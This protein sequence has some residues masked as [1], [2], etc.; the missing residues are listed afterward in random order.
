MP[1]RLDRQRDRVGDVGHEVGVRRGAEG[2]AHAG[3]QVEVLDRRRYAVQRPGVRL[4]PAA[5]D[6]AR[7]RASSGVRGD[8]RA[9]LVGRARGSASASSRGDTSP[10]R[11]AA[12]CSSAVRS[13]SSLTRPTL[14]ASLQPTRGCR[15]SPK[16]MP[17]EQGLPR[18]LD[19]VVPDADG[20]PRRLAV[21]GLDQDPGDRVGAVT[22]VEDPHLVVDQLE[23]RDLRERLHQRLPQR[24]VEGVDRAVALAGLD[25]PHALGDAASRSPRRRPPPPARRGSASR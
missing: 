2:R 14:A 19:H 6:S 4:A 16:V 25:V 20:H 18:R 8:E 10:R 5:S 21:G 12:P 11:T 13:C 22:L 3:G 24:L 1:G 9:D 23:L 15:R 17:V 7:A